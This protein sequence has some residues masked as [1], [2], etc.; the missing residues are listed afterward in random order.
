MAAELESKVVVANDQVES[1]SVKCDCCGLIEECTMEYIEKVREKHLGRWIC[2]L[3]SEA[4]KDEIR[5]SGMRI[6]TEEAMNR[7]IIFFKKFRS[8]SPP[9]IAAEHWVA[10]VKKILIK[11]LDSPRADCRSKIVPQ[12]C[13]LSEESA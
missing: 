1:E 10:A 5:R 2:G 9:V 8:V 3:C 12:N 4:V 13:E 7:H 6:S 11:C